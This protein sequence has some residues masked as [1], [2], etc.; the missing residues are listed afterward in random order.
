MV[1]K[2]F[3]DQAGDDGALSYAVCFHMEGGGQ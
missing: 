2:A 3:F 1:N